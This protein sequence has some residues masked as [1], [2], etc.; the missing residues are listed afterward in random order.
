[1]I[2]TYTELMQRE[3]FEARFQYLALHGAVGA[4]T[5]GFDRYLNQR[6]YTSRRWRSVREQIMIRDN[7]SDLGIEGFEIH[8][9]LTIHHLNPMTIS[10]IMADDP[11]TIDPE[12]LITTTHRTH[13]AIHFG[14]ESLLML[15][16]VE[17]R[18]G[19]TT[20]W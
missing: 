18:P 9:R 7:G 20:L 3:T 6:F 13:N 16:P 15:P 10:E 14:D 19:D 11:R 8:G 2:R 1:M 17:R 5:F 12:N 4:E